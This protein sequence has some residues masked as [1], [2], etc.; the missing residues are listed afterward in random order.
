MKKIEEIAQKLNL[1]EENIE[2]YGNYKAKINYQ[3]ENLKGKL[4]LVTSVSPTTYGEGKT[5]MSLGL[6]D[7]FRKLNKNSV[8]VLREPSLGPVFGIK[9]GATGGGMAKVVPENDI[10]LHFTGDMHAI[11]SANNLLSAAIDNHIY[12][13]NEKSFIQ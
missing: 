5:T 11:T 9:G 13:G 7:A 10:N 3:N 6:N 2:K 1:K 8:A 4:I 12:Q